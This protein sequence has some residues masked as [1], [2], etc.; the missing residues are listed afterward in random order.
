MALEAVE[1]RLRRSPLLWPSLALLAGVALAPAAPVVRPLL[2]LPVG[3]VALA[4]L[5][6]R[7]GLLPVTVALW[8]LLAAIVRS[9][10]AGTLAPDDISAF[11]GRFVEL[12]GVVAEEPDVRERSALVR[13]RVLATVG[14]GRNNPAWQP[15]SGTLQL[16]VPLTQS[17]AYGDVLDVRGTAQ[18]PPILPGFDYRD[19]LARQGVRSSMTYAR[20]TLLSNGAGDPLHAAIFALRERIAAELQ[21]ALPEPEASLQRAIL[22]GTRSATF[23]T[24]TPDFIRTGMIHIVATSGFKVA[25]VGGSLL[26]LCTPLLG[27]RRAAIPALV[28]V[29][30]YILLTGATPA[31]LRAGLR[32]GLMWGLA[33]GALLAGRPT[34]SLQGLTLAAAGMVAFQ[35]AVLGDSGFQ[36][37]AGATA[38]ILLLQPRFEVW[39]HRLPGW[40]AEPV[41]VTLAAQ[42]ATLPVT[43]VGFHQVSLIAPL[44]NLICLPVLP[45]AMAAGALVAVAGAISPLLAHLAGLAAFGFLAYMIA[46]V[47]LLARFPG[48]AVAAPAVGA[49]FALFYYA[50]CLALLPALPE[51]LS[52]ARRPERLTL[53]ARLTMSCGLTLLLAVVYLLRGAPPAQAELTFLDVG[54]GDALLVR[55][56][57]GQSVLIDV[58]AGKQALSAQ[59]GTILPFWTRSLDVLVLTG[60]EATHAGAAVDLATRYGFGQVLVPVPAAHPSLTAVNLRTGLPSSTLT[61]M[62]P[63]TAEFRSRGG[64][65]VDALPIG[66]A[67][68]P[69]LLVFLHIGAITLL[70]AAALSPAD[71][72][73]ALLTDSSLRAAILI[74][75]RGA[76]VGALDP[77]FF[78]A[79]QPNIILAA[80]LVPKTSAAD[81]GV[82][83]VLRTDQVG[84]VQ[85]LSNGKTV[86]LE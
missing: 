80:A 3:V 35:P 19:Y 8:L 48:G 59:L 45:A 1:E 25:I 83:Q 52:V 51:P 70:D 23:S 74:A 41:G 57:T 82:V 7:P 79:V 12:Q 17:Y 21:A 10:A 33:L 39:L 13:V 61:V 9:Q 68:T 66:A 2:L 67:S 86:T 77:A 54:T 43:M 47:Q 55:D 29:A 62:P 58:G 72:R 40:L 24:L 60:T 38:G 4:A 27:R 31:G 63:A 81:F 15:A 11:N 36:L 76:A 84:M 73:Q 53:A 50:G 65:I 46:A 26:G 75:P 49:G 71:Q 78:A 56:V 6:V 14:G 28:G 42:V 64:V 44:A 37:S 16:R 32:A 18:A 30:I 22:I 69:H 5:L 20:I 85:L 34:A